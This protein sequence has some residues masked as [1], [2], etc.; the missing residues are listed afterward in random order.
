[1][2]VVEKLRVRAVVTLQAGT[3]GYLV[4]RSNRARQQC[5]SVIQ[6][7]WRGYC[8][9][10]DLARLARAALVIQAAWR[11]FSAR[12]CHGGDALARA[13]LPARLPQESGLSPR[14]S[15][16]RCFQSC[17][18]QTCHLCQSLS[19]G[20]GSAPSVVMLVGSSPR[21][22]HMCGQTVPTRVVHGLGQRSGGHSAPRPA[23]SPEVA[24][25]LIQAAWKGFHV[26]REHQQQQ[27]A[28]RRL[29]A[30]WR[31]HATR[32]SFSTNGLLGLD[33]WSSPAP[34]QWRSV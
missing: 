23:P 2:Q 19:P 4:R 33:S 5:A 3:R 10:R 22:C 6:A 24:A 32:A 28:A 15:D 13:P 16:H 17:Q 25:T 1:M 30:S 29:Q 11:G 7:A 8:V 26:R 34:E 18:P 12:H 14:I 20:L 9:R 31:G 27:E 21:T